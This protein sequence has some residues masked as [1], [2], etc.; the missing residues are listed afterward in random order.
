MIYNGNFVVYI[1]AIMT[2]RAAFAKIIIIV[3]TIYITI[4]SVLFLDIIMII[5]IKINDKTNGILLEW[6]M[7]I[8]LKRKAQAEKERENAKD[9]SYKID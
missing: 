8:V 3:I 4:M 1:T 9:Q 5:L 2:T 6:D 7:N